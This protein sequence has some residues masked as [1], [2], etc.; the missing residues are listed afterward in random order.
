MCF[1]QPDRLQRGREHMA[2][3]FAQN[4]IIFTWQKGRKPAPI[5]DYRQGQ[6]YMKAPAQKNFTNFLDSLGR[7]A[8]IYL[9]AAR[10]AV[11]VAGWSSS[12]ARRAHNPKAVGSN[13]APA[14][15]MK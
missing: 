4:K 10:N 12:V 1:A 13:P 5:A 8:Y 2:E 7:C 14:T 11:C 15:R 6:A 9:L 3:P